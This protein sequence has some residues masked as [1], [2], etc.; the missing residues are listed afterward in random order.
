[1]EINND[2]INTPENTGNPRE[3][4]FE[5][6]ILE[7]VEKGKI[8]LDK[9]TVEEENHV[10][11]VDKSQN[12]ISQIDRFKAEIAQHRQYL[13]NDQ[14]EDFKQYDEDVEYK[15][16]LEK[17][18]LTLGDE[19]LENLPYPYRKTRRQ[20]EAEEEEAKRKQERAKR[21]FDW[22][23]NNKK[24]FVRDSTVDV[25][26]NEGEDPTAPPK[27]E[28]QR[29]NVVNDF[30]ATYVQMLEQPRKDFEQMVGEGLISKVGVLLITIGV[31]T[32][33]SFVE[34]EGLLKDYMRIV[35]GIGIALGMLFAAHRMRQTNQTFSSL[36][37]YGSL[38]VFYFTIYLGSD[39]YRVLNEAFAFF[40]DTLITL[41]A[42]ALAVLYDRRSLAI[43]GII[44]AYATPFLV[45]ADED[46]SNTLFFGYLAMMNG[47]MA[48]VA[49]YKKWQF[50]NIAIFVLTVITFDGWIHHPAT[51]LLNADIFSTAIAF[52]AVY[53][54]F[55]F[56]VYTAY[57]WRHGEQM[58]FPLV[59]N[60][61]LSFYV[62]VRLLYEHETLIADLGSYTFLF[63]LV[64]A[65]F[66]MVLIRHESFEERLINHVAGFAVFLV[67]LAIFV[68]MSPA[69]LNPYW[70][71]E[72]LLLVVLGYYGRLQ[73]LRNASALV[74]VLAFGS[75]FINWYQ[76]YSQ[77]APTMFFNTAVFATVITIASAIISA[78]VLNKDTEAE[79]IIAIRKQVYMGVIGGV[80]GLL[81]YMIGNVELQFHNYEV[82][83]VKRLWIGIYNSI[84]I[85]TL[86]SVGYKTK[87]LAMKKAA[88]YL[89]AFS[90]AL[91]IFYVH[92]SVI[93]L[94]NEYL[95][96]NQ[97]FSIFAIHYI[98][99]ILSIVMV[100]LMITDV[101]KRYTEN[102][103]IFS[104]LIWYV[105]FVLMFHASAELDH[106]VTLLFYE[107]GQELDELL[108]VVHRLPYSVLWTFAAVGIMYV[109]MRYQLKDLR[110]IALSIFGIMLL[111][112][113]ILDFRT[114]SMFARVLSLMFLGGVLLVVSFMYGQIKK[115]IMEGDVSAI[116]DKFDRDAKF[117]ANNHEIEN[118][119]EID[120]NENTVDESIE[121]EEQDNTEDENPPK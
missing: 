61:F 32:L 101:Y 59:I 63:G 67:T 44:G 60:T 34:T 4:M 120:K 14:E 37:I 98:N 31:F 95:M 65:I 20:K 114:I 79:N 93:D 82:Q 62:V 48:V 54:V 42:L 50:I 121:E 6:E 68:E 13:K 7:T 27:T 11:K 38:A 24:T 12:L 84:F 53:Y 75:L 83:D 108:Y 76:T 77:S 51:D 25:M 56:I 119:N 80:A 64:N 26:Q 100:L 18:D 10:A 86:W 39:K 21:G 85:L 22:D 16:L 113:F 105:I 8:T 17:G 88:D 70:A 69:E 41:V 118:S 96:L 23:E 78:I 15:L 36:F 57:T 29:K 49:N 33:L 71:M 111:K 110:M 45:N 58:Y 97:P 43:L 87:I 55:F 52:A 91:Y 9:E 117:T 5:E 3:K 47:F 92:F 66:T 90:A 1:M 94:R 81:L 116:R 35:L 30:N 103:S 40:L 28:Q 104:Y 74:M 106:T 115:V 73:I 112:F 99:V 89:V 46:F 72:A 109:G 107:Q 19:E 2:D 102:S